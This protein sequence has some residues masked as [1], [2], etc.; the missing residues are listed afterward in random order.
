MWE[1]VPFFSLA[2]EGTS[3]YQFA[4]KNIA[5]GAGKQALQAIFA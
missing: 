3:S 2:V 5:L 1:C 4:S